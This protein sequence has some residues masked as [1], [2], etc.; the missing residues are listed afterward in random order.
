MSENLKK[1]IQKRALEKKSRLLVVAKK[2]FDKNGFYNT[3]IKDI[4]NE[5][6]VSI[7][8]FYN[9]FKDKNDIYREV[10]E[11]ICEKEI[12]RHKDFKEKLL[13]TKD[14]KKVIRQYIESSLEVNSNKKI[15]EEINIIKNEFPEIEHILEKAHGIS[16]QI[17]EEI[18]LS[19]WDNTKKSKIKVSAN[20]IRR[21]ASANILTVLNIEDE[22]LKKEYI[23][24]LVNLI[25]N[26]LFW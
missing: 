4:T 6:G 22:G 5:A 21:T 13:L 20:I 9:Y 8:L 17:F 19:L 10:I 11:T 18:L 24:E 7:G 2:L 1:P 23:E 25:Y 12:D 15:L 3:F 16:Q 14:K 26:Y